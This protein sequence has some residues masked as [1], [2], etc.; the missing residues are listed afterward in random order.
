MQISPYLRKATGGFGHWCPGCKEMH[1]VR[2]EGDKHPL[3]VLTN[4]DGDKPSLT[5][6]VRITC[7]HFMDGFVAGS[8]C[9]CTYNAE[10]PAEAQDGFECSSCHYILTDGMLYFCPD[11]SHALSGQTVP[12]PPL[13]ESLKDCA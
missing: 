1:I 10:H 4:G 13:P 7:G 5:P 2:T 8:R 6:S 3:W 11:S 9:W 12:L